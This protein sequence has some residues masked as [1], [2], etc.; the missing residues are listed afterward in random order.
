[1]VKKL[2]L[3]LVR[4]KFKED[5]IYIFG[6]FDLQK[7]F[8]VSQNTANLFISRNVKQGNIRKLR[9]KFYIFFG[10]HVNEMLIANKI[11]EPSY[12][13]FEYALMFYGIIPDTVY[14]VTSAT[15]RITR[16]F[17]INNISYPYHHIKRGA[18]TG[19]IKKYFNG[20]MAFIAE[21]EKAFIDYLY[22]VN[23]GKKVIYDRLDVGRLS[24]NK[25]ITYAQ[26]FKR[27]SLSKLVNKIYDQARRNR[28]IIY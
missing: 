15:T 5:G 11:Y 3:N 16:E 27:K 6:P 21:P 1:M 12:I 9:K 13:S 19:Y 20:Q 4:N 28:K 22:F 25:L 2:K 8:S 18:F 26:L 10:E 23:L 7:Y 24:K 14:T 17:V